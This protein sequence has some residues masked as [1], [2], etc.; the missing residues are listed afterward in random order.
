MTDSEATKCESGNVRHERQCRARR[1]DENAEESTT[2]M[3]T[4]DGRGKARGEDVRVHN[5]ARG[6]RRDAKNAGDDH[7]ARPMPRRATARRV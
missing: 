7:S 2:E 4:R 6:N 3:D 1:G 5:A